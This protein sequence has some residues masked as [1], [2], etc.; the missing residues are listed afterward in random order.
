MTLPGQALQSVSTSS[1]IAEVILSA[2]RNW[3]LQFDIASNPNVSVVAQNQITLQYH[4]S[5]QQVVNVEL[6]LSRRQ[7]AQI[8]ASVAWPIASHWDAYAR[9]V[10]SLLDN[11]AATPAV[12]PGA[13]ERFRRVPVPRSLLEHPCTLATLDQ[14]PHRQPEQRCLPAA[15]THGAVQCRKRHGRASFLEQSIRGYSSSAGRQ[16]LF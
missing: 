6:P 7:L 10:Y 8:D 16:P 1:L 12:R 13:I 9:A 5:N 3:N 11:P 4:P 2:Y 15:G 14:H